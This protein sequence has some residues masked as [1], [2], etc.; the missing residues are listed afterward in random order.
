MNICE[1][2]HLEELLHCSLQCSSITEYNAGR[3]TS[4]HNESD[5]S[6]YIDNFSDMIMLLDHFMNLGVLKM[7]NGDCK[8]PPFVT[9]LLLELF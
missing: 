3:N 4:I 5:N 2:Q 6:L 9:P 8:S 7:T 1:K